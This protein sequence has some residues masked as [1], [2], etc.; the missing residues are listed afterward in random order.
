MTTKHR[1]INSYLNTT[2]IPAKSQSDCDYLKYNY[3][4]KF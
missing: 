3:I 1:K 4:I 2:I